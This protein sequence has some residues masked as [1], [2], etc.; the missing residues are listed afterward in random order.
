MGHFTFVTN[1]FCKDDSVMV[2]ETFDPF[3]SKEQILT[4][5]SKTLI[6]KLMFKE[7]LLFCCRK[8][9]NNSDIMDKPLKSYND[10]PSV[11]E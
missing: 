10:A 3:R 4:D 7:F 6:Q 1:M 11:F 8:T 5:E 2:F 9:T